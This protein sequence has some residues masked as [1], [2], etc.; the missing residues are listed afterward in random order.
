MLKR[1]KGPFTI[2]RTDGTTPYTATFI[3]K[4]GS[5]TVL[6]YS[7]GDDRK[8]TGD[9]GKLTIEEAEGVARA[10]VIGLTK[11]SEERGG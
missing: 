7:Y 8:H 10:I 3:V 2:T 1:I 6:S 5:G 11:V 4:D 9:V